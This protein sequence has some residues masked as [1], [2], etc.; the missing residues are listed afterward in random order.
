M[1]TNLT[2]TLRGCQVFGEAMLSRGYGRNHQYRIALHLLALFEVAAY[3][4]SKAAVGA[5]T[6]P[7]PWNVTQECGQRD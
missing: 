7:W 4:A 2:G 1:E 3:C 6:K 5:L